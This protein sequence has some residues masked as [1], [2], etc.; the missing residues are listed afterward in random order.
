MTSGQLANIG[1]IGMA[2]MGSNLARN[3]AHRGHRV[4]VYNRTASKTDA[5]I[6]EHGSE[7][8]TVTMKI[9]LKPFRTFTRSRTLP[10][11]TRDPEVIKSVAR[12]LLD[13]FDP[14]DPVRLIGVYIAGSPTTRMPWLLS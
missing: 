2:V 11:R 4:A 5:V 6:A 8:R 9:R 1:V 13:K 7:G 3:L 14:P 10:S 12:D